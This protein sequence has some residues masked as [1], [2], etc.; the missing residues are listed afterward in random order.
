MPTIAE[1]VGRSASAASTSTLVR[2]FGPRTAGRNDRPAEQ[3]VRRGARIERDE[4]AP[5]RPFASDGGPGVFAA[6]VKRELGKYEK[7]VR[8]RGA[9][10]NMTIRHNGFR[11]NRSATRDRTLCRGH[12]SRH[13]RR[14]DRSR[15][16]ALRRR[17]GLDS[18]DILEVAL[19]VSQRYGF[20]LR[21]DDEDNVASS[22]RW[23][24]WPS[25]SPQPSA[26][27]S[28][29]RRTVLVGLVAR[30]TSPAALADDERPAR[31]GTRSS[32]SARC[33]PCSPCC[34]RRWPR[35]ALSWPPSAGRGAAAGLAHGAAS[36]RPRSTWRSTSTS[37]SPWR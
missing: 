33:S 6:F 11:T 1:A 4:G 21:S 9:G 18:I 30:P 15:G 19:V 3:G 35:L 7:V 20:Q 27:V 5:G 26:A 12:Q 22:G 8:P 17:L 31:A 16:A 25:T 10:S 23:R 29:A 34:R 13:R 14:G 32:S 36:R 28:D 2:I 24:A 37:M